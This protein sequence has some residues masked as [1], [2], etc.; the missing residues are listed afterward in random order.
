MGRKQASQ[1]LAGPLPG[2]SAG[3]NAGHARM[4]T[5][6]PPVWR[7]AR[8]RKAEKKK[9]RQRTYTENLL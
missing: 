2:A 3:V 4:I 8:P 7:E 1:V 9:E 5:C 6:F